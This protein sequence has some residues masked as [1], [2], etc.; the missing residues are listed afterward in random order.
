MSFSLTSFK[1][2]SDNTQIFLKAQAGASSTMRRNGQLGLKGSVLWLKAGLPC[3]D[4]L[5]GQ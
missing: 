3:V 1:E 2:F 5:T 4:F